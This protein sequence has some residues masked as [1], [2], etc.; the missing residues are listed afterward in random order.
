MYD[1][2]VTMPIDRA[3]EIMGG[4]IEPSKDEMKNGWTAE[5]LTIYMAERQ[6]TAADRLFKKPAKPKRTKS[7]MK[8]LRR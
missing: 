7:R 2:V 3:T 4:L 6:L 8:W 5:S 1:W